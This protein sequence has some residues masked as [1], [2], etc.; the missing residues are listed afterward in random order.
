MC[1]MKMKGDLMM[2]RDVPEENHLTELTKQRHMMECYFF[3]R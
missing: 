2:P 3:R 1:D